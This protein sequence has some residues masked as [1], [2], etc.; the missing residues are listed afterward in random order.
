MHAIYGWLYKALQLYS[1]WYH[2][3][4]ICTLILLYLL[5]LSLFDWKSERMKSLSCGITIA[6][7]AVFVISSLISVRAQQEPLTLEYASLVSSEC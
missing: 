7:L 1:Y 5:L 3:S 4:E 6:L 2:N